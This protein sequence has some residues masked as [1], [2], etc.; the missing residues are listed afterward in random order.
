MVNGLCPLPSFKL[1]AIIAVVFFFV[2]II[3]DVISAKMLKSEQAS[4]KE[5]E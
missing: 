5:E 3:L 4:K 1:Y 2:S